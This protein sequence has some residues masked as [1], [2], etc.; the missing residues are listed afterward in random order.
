MTDEREKQFQSAFG[1]FPLERYPRIKNTPLRAW[2]AADELALSHLKEQIDS[3]A[4]PLTEGQLRILTVNDQDGALA[5]SAENIPS[6]NTTYCWSDS[7]LSQQS[8]AYNT[9][10]INSDSSNTLSVVAPT[11]IASTDALDGFYD[12]VLIQVPKTLSL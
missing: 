12:I 2:S 3:G 1:A 8:L 11:F 7:S 5:F 4:F 6:K 9:N 10:L